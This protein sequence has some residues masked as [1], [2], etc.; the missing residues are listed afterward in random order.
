M[1]VLLWGIWVYMFVLL[2]L[3]EGILCPMHTFGTAHTRDP[4]LIQLGASVVHRALCSSSIGRCAETVCAPCR[5]A[6]VVFV[7]Y[8]LLPYGRCGGDCTMVI[9]RC[10][11]SDVELIQAPPPPLQKKPCWNFILKITLKRGC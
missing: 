3:L 11:A 6:P 9:G 7:W 5:N 8:Q 2:M 10:G 1:L 4:T